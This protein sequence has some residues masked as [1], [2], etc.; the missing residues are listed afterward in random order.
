MLHAAEGAR[1]GYKN[2]Q[3]WTVDSDAV[4]LAISFANRI[5]CEQLHLHST[6][7]AFTSPGREGGG[8]G[9]VSAVRKGL[10]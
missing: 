5:E 4:V 9:G 10:H 1:Q 6:E 7:L 3:I 8:G 2:I